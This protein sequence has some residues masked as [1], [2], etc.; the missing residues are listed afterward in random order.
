MSHVGGE[1]LSSWRGDHCNLRGHQA[2][3]PRPLRTVVSL[4]VD[5]GVDDGHQ[6]GGEDEAECEEGGGRSGGESLGG[7]MGVA[8]GP[9]LPVRLLL[10]SSAIQPSYSQKIF[11]KVEKSSVGKSK[12]IFN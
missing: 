1:G 2:A 11:C 6:Q 3:S 10:T 7:V 5:L 9:Q 12:N 4:Q 8:P